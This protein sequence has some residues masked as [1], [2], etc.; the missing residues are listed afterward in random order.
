MS[1][2]V[3]NQNVK[4]VVASAT[5]AIV[6]E[7]TVV[8]LRGFFGVG[9]AG[10]GAVELRSGG[11]AGTLL[12]TIPAV[13]AVV[14][15]SADFSEPIKFASGLHATFAATAMTITFLYETPVV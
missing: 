4:G 10:A 8:Y 2:R 9:I 7:G 14:G 6:A 5:A 11:A 13:A 12:Y 1:S 3:D 15:F